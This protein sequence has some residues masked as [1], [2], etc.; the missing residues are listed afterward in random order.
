MAEHSPAP[1][2]STETSAVGLVI[3]DYF[4]AKALSGLLD[5]C[6]DDDHPGVSYPR[7]VAQMAYRLADEMLE[8]RNA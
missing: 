1:W 5:V 8:A 4:A 6:R 3:R 2:M 7:H